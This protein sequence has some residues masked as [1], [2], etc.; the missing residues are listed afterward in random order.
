[1][2][3]PEGVAGSLRFVCY[4]CI[5]FSVIGDFPQGTLREIS[6]CSTPHFISLQFPKTL[7][8]NLCKLSVGLLVCE[9]RLHLFVV[10]LI[11]SIERYKHTTLV[12]LTLLMEV[13][14]WMLH[15]KK[16][17]ACFGNSNTKFSCPSKRVGSDPREAEKWFAF[18]IGKLPIPEYWSSPGLLCCR[19]PL[20]LL[21]N[22]LGSFC[23]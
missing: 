1:M 14:V 16:C 22:H 21:N 5:L 18:N 13:K 23:G 12:L 4:C 3:I 6:Q 17:F 19:C 7:S 2:L 10:W 9:S 11:I 20:L 15:H 8:S